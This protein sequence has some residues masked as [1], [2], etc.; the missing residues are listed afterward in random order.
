MVGELPGEG[1][2]ELAPLGTQ[3]GA[4]Q[5]GQPL[6]VTLAL[7][8]GGQHGPAGDPEDVAGDHT[9]L[10]LGVL[11]QLLDPLLLGGAHRH[12]VGAVAGQ[13]PQPPDHRWRH[14]AGPQHAPLGQLGKPH[15]I[16][17]VG[18][19][20][21]RQV[22]D[23]LGVDQPDLE[24]LGLQQIKGRLPV[25]A[26][27]LHDHPGHAQLGQPVGQGQQRAGHRGVGGDLLQPLACLARHPH[28]ADKLGLADVQ[29]RDPLHDLLGLVG[30]LQHPASLP[31]ST[32]R[33]P[34]EPQGP[35]EADPRAQGDTEGP[36]RS[37]QRPT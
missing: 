30:L 22:L 2:P 13:V 27:G 5:L 9:Q 17:L 11:Q 25:V 21:A 15:R 8:E 36:K 10:D 18:L 12:Q 29:R 19:G 16:Q 34:Q 20:P 26:G 24:S 33:C 35:G 4:G 23:I 6:G 7:D 1:L 28:A 37:S 3:P 32:A 14:E 31:W